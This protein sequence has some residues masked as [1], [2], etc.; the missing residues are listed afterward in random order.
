MYFLPAAPFPVMEGEPGALLDLGEAD[1]LRGGRGG[2]RT[3][4]GAAM[5][6]SDTVDT[7]ASAVRNTARRMVHTPGAD[8]TGVG[9]SVS[10]HPRRFAARDPLS[11]TS[12]VGGSV[13]PL[14]LI[15]EVT[16]S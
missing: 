1:G 7:A 3:R 13:E 2:L 14:S 8:D 15:A 10:M 5:V 12:P 9:K 16:R 4:R 11:Y 6:R